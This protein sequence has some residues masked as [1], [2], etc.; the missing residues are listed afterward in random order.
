MNN[1]LTLNEAGSLL[2]G[3]GLV[4]ISSDT[5]IGLILVGVGA[6]LKIAVAVLGKYGIMVSGTNQQ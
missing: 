2:L 5:N 3:A 1:T 6:V 4:Q